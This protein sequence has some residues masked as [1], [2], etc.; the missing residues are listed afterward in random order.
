[1]PLPASASCLTAP[2]GATMIAGATARRRAPRP[3][4]AATLILVRQQMD[5]PRLLM[6]RRN[7]GHGFMPGKWVFPGGR[8]ARADF[9]AP[10]ASEPRPTVAC[11]VTRNLAPGRLRALAA[12]AVR[13]TF[14]ETGL[15]LAAPAATPAGK[16]WRDFCAN[17]RAPD[18]GALT[19]IARMI[20]PP[21]RPQ[22]FDTFFFLADAAR[23]VSQQPVDTRELE[24]VDWFAMND[25]EALDLPRPTRLIVAELRARFAGEQRAPYY[26]RF[27]NSRE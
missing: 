22:R 25:I 16:A 9:V 11:D 15:L 12:A 14:E 21:H 2:D 4:H 5:G 18:L 8:L 6:G 19:L 26:R 17:G 23:L 27:R 3:R 24:E 20:T 13:E 1:M 10:A 7:A